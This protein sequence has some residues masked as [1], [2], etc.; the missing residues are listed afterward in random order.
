MATPTP[1]PKPDKP[2]AAGAFGDDFMRARQARRLRPLAVSDDGKGN[3]VEVPYDVPAWFTR[4]GLRSAIIDSGLGPVTIARPGLRVQRRMDEAQAGL[5]KAR[6]HH[7]A[8]VEAKADK[9]VVDAAREGLEIA[10]A[11]QTQAMVHFVTNAIVEIPATWEVEIECPELGLARN[12]PLP[13]PSSV[14]AADPEKQEA[15]LTLLPPT[16]PKQIMAAMGVLEETA[17]IPFDEVRVP[18]S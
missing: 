18:P 2:T 10:A 15:F 5:E 4:V 12:T 13:A 7:N 14:Y 11:K 1:L 9:A 8:V 16:L 17:P 6:I 3:R